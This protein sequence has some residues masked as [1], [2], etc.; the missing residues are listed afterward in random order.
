MMVKNPAPSIP[1][2]THTPPLFGSIPTPASAPAPPPPPHASTSRTTTLTT[3]ENYGTTNETT[4][5]KVGLLLSLKMLLL[6][7]LLGVCLDATTLPL[8]GCTGEARARFMAQHL[9]GSLLLHWV[10]AG[11]L[12]CVVHRVV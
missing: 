9:V 3:N 11:V 5:E 8:F 12:G 6:P 7:L 10:S 2:S 1:L 4:N